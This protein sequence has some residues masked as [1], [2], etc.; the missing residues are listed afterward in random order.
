MAKNNITSLIGDQNRRMQ[1]AIAVLPTRLGNEAVRWSKERFR[2]QG[3]KGN[4]NQPWKKRKGNTDPSRATLV[5]SGALKRSVRM[6]GVTKYTSIIGTDS[7]CARAH[8][9]GAQGT[10]RVRAHDRRTYSRG[11]EKNK[12]RNTPMT[13]RQPGTTTV[14]AHTRKVN[15]PQRRFLGESPDLTRRLK[16]EVHETLKDYGLLDS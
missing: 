8:N 14:K 4:S 1:L 11:T 10:V 5:K 2:Q 15:I 16:K 12:G 7:P 6:I 9:E 3:W 13:R